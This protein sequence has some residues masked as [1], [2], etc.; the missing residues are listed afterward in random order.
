[1]LKT[2]VKSHERA[3][4]WI[5]LVRRVLTNLHLKDETCQ[6][7]SYDDPMAQALRKG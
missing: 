2:E 1:V 4:G 5:P 3:L 7:V 6:E